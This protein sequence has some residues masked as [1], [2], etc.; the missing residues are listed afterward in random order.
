VSYDIIRDLADN[1]VREVAIQ[2]S[3]TES[4]IIAAVVAALPAESR[5]AYTDFDAGVDTY[6]YALD[7]VGGGANALAVIADVARSAY[8][9]VA[10]LGNGTLRLINRSSRQ[11]TPLLGA[12]SLPETSQLGLDAPMTLDGAYNFVRVTIHPKSIGE[13][14]VV[15]YGL[16]G[17][18]PSIVAGETMT[19]W[20]AYNDPTNA[21]RLIGA[22]SVINPLSSG[23][24]YAGNLSSDG[25]GADATGDLSITVTP[26]AS[27]AKF[28]VQNVGAAAVWLTTTST[29]P[30]TPHLQLR[31][32]G[33]YDEGVQTFESRSTQAYGNNPVEIDMPYQADATVGQSAAAYIQG[34]FNGE[35]P[36]VSSVTL[37][38]DVQE[39]GVDPILAALE[40]GVAVSLSETMTGL[41]A[42]SSVINR[43]SLEVTPGPR[44]V[45]TLGIAPLVATAVWELGTAGKSELDSTT[46]LG[47]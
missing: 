17:V 19:F 8:A 16:S 37:D 43:V 24:D 33:V 23:T 20:G 39:V 18:V 3:Q 42:H 31:G 46:I 45:A 22:T 13:S 40:P 29:D 6:P 28:A 38:L 15:L 30:I 35:W 14:T 44:T 1:N 47:F 9:F 26:F 21:Q 27:A 32:T 2:V 36:Q 41:S 5:P 34:L 12:W 11:T 10:C 25:N 4:Q 7:L